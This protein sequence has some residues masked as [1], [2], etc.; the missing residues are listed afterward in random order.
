MNM[1]M[2]MNTARVPSCFSV[3]LS[4]LLIHNH[5]RHEMPRHDRLSFRQICYGFFV[6]SL[7]GT[8]IDLNQTHPHTKPEPLL[9]T[10]FVLIQYLGYELCM[11]KVCKGRGYS[12]A[13]SL[14]QHSLG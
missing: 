12:G 11:G 7:K 8:Y 1:N 4:W 6:Y 14:N 2:N 3:K 5:V 10:T 13:L 9:S